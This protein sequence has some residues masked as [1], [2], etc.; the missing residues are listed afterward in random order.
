MGDVVSL[1]AR[2]QD[3][4]DEE[5]AKI[6]N[7]K[8]AKNKF[9][10]DDFLSQIQQLKKMGNMKD[11]MGMIP[12]MG[13][14]TKDLDVDNDSFKHIEAIIH[15]MTPKERS[16]PS[17]LNA[18]RKKRIALGSGRSIQEVNQLLKQFTQ[19][20]KMMKMMQGGGARN[21]MRM[22]QQQGEPGRMP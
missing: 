10:Y 2:A 20:S 8:I 19:M 12:G 9:G 1:V 15:S 13:K 4:F 17:L 3:Q 14:M 7:K 18:S 5:Q 11:L 21:M 16:N 22:M 6:I